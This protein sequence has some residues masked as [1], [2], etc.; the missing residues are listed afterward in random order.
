MPSRIAVIK[1]RRSA[2][3]RV[4]ATP[5]TVRKLIALGF[6]V[7]VEEGAGVSASVPDADYAAAG[8]SLAKT[9][10]AAL[11]DADVVLK[12]R[13]PEAAE[14]AALKSGAVLVAL[15]NPYN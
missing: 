12:V 10:A 1:E 3:T 8:A 14:I 2:E 13:A 15:L 7:S 6:S 5:D 9:A 11:K 4:A